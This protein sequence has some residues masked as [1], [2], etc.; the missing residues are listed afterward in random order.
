M[1]RIGG[2]RPSATERM[3]RAITSSVTGRRLVAFRTELRHRH[4][5]THW[6][7][8]FGIVTLACVVVVFVTGIALMFFYQP[9]GTQVR[10]EGSYAPLHGSVL[11]EALRST[12][13][14][15]FDVRGGL[16]LRQAHHWAALLLPAAIIQQLL[17]AFF[18]GGFR[19]PRKG[20]WV[21]LF[22]I[23]IVALAGG[24]SGYALPDDMLSGTGV[25]ITQG[26]VLGIPVVGTWLSAASSPGRSSSICTRC[27]S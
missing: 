4:A 26:I 18:T 5:P 15:S 16:L 2:H 9:S 12:L 11:S 3:S 6:T 14:I 19:R 20:M 7:N 1:R 10:Y 22:G 13:S 23:L 24:W 8:L 27:T 21:L 25:R 17:V